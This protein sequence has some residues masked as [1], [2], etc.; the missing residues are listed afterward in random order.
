[1]I[2]R[3]EVKNFKNFKENLIFDLKSKNHYEY[4]K[5]SIKEINDNTIVKTGL[6]FG[7]NGSG[8]SNL[9]SAMFDIITT[10]TDKEK[11]LNI[12]QLYQNLNTTENQYA[13]FYYKLNFNSNI[14]EYKYKK[15]DVQD[16]VYEELK[17][18]GEIYLTYDHISH[19]G[20]NALKGAENLNLDLT[21][22]KISFVK[23]VYN[24]SVLDRNDINVNFG[25]FISF[26]E[27]MLIFSSL[28]KNNFQGFKSGG[29]KLSSAIIEKGL[30]KDFENFLH[31][32]NINY[33]LK[34][35]ESDG[36]KIILVEF[37]NK[38][39]NFFSVAS[40]GTCSLTLFYFWLNHL[41][42]VSFVFIDEFDAFYHNELAL[43]VVKQVKNRNAQAILT[44]HNTSIMNNEIMRPDCLFNL[45]KNSITSFSN[46]TDKELRKA[47]NMEKMYRGGSFGT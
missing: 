26:V 25:K 40:R 14:V 3:F 20:F 17:I 42:D 1:M 32:S 46:L 27:N 2:E 12:Y 28:E 33:N 47:H 8:K 35:G 18:N 36:D 45:R 30:L 6:V 15:K 31:N 29:E 37:E 43:E 22:T 13:E 9:G 44:T 5:D 39:V 23:Y 34:E 41:D 16:L 4:N 24:N 19:V 10:L 11:T 21:N 7:M 38:S